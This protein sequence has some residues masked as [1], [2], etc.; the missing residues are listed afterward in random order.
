MILQN[1]FC[2]QNTGLNRT[3]QSLAR[4]C[5]VK[6]GTFLLFCKF[7]LFIKK[8]TC[9]TYFLIQVICHIQNSQ[10]TINLNLYGK[11]I[12]YA[13]FPLA[14]STYRQLKSCPIKYISIISRRSRVIIKPY[15]TFFNSILNDTRYD[16]F[17]FL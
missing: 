8:L 10:L 14:L 1:F 11:S 4:R 12:F 17:I 3:I 7:R 5:L 16:R 13:H 6:T 2:T 15:I 9:T